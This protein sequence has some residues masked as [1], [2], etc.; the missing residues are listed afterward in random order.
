VGADFAGGVAYGF[1]SIGMEVVK[2]MGI[3]IKQ[4]LQEAV[5]F[6]REKGISLPH[7]EA[8]IIL[9]FL[10]GR[11]KPY[12]YAHGE[13]KIVPKIKRAYREMLQHR[14]EGIP[15]AYIT[16]KKEFMELTFSVDKSVLIPRPETE[17][18]VEAVIDWSNRVFKQ[19]EKE[20]PLRILDLGT[21]CG[22]IAVS[23]AY[24][25]PLSLVTGVDLEKKAIELAY[26]NAQNAGV[27][28]RIRFLYGSCWEPL[29]PDEDKFNIIVSN[30]PYVSHAELPL[31]SP[32]VQNEPRLALNGGID[33]LD[34]YRCIF[35][36]VQRYFKV[37]GP[38]LLALEIGEKQV[39]PV[40]KMSSRFE[41]LRNIKVIKD[42]AGIERVILFSIANCNFTQVVLN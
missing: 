2:V 32:E 31:L 36:G 6:L 19:S 3:S 26:Q 5:S 20:A 39:D 41:F 1:R 33:G 24:Y 29:S 40:L 25:L 9:A 18:L 38:G 17:H 8:E 10:L 11:D 7:N 13:E 35:S 22:N 42:Y 14:S 37:P 28:E 21:G 12:L 30:P 16:E 23:L 15:L 27:S 4:A 34:A